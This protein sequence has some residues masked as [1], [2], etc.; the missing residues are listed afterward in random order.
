MTV[1]T[2]GDILQWKI[3]KSDKSVTTI[4]VNRKNSNK[5]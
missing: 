2:V 4:D 1:E 3:T 5:Y